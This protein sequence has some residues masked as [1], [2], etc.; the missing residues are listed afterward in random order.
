MDASIDAGRLNGGCG[1]GMGLAANA[2]TPPTKGEVKTYTSADFYAADGTF[3]KDKARE[4]YFDMFQRFGYPIP[5]G[6]RR[7]CGFL[8][9]A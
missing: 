8:T 5:I 9:S 2:T 3:R 4:A 1:G 6:S 7:R